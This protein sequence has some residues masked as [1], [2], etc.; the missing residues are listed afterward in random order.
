MLCS[1]CDN[2]NAS[3]VSSR[4]VDVESGGREYVEC[5]EI[6]GVVQNIWTPDVFWDG[7]P[8]ENLADGPDGKPRVFSSKRDKALY[9]RSKGIFEAGDFRHGAPMSAVDIPARNSLKSRE[10]V[11]AAM[12][13]VKNMGIDVRRR[14]MAKINKARSVAMGL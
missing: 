12:N 9:L 14:E 6:C 11:R 8:E 1:G 4:F 2:Q 13:K 7:K 10:Q 3:H 5:C